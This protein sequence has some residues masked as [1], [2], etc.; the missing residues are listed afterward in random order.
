[1]KQ[2][3]YINT[4]P[5]EGEPHKVVLESN[6]V[7]EQYGHPYPYLISEDFLGQQGVASYKEK[8]LNA[9]YALMYMQEVRLIMLALYL[10][11]G[12]TL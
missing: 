7:R 6:C 9:G 4:S 11:V 1:M 3:V 12:G 10:M 2:Y 8:L 5:R